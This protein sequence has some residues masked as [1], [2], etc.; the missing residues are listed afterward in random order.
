MLLAGQHP[1]IVQLQPAKHHGPHK[2]NTCSS[3]RSN[4]RSQLLQSRQ[5]K[6]R[7]GSVGQL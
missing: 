7:A 4:Q 6:G 3:S 1:A 5:S 2:T